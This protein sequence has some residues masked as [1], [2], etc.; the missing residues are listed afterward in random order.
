MAGYKSPG[1]K[2]VEYVGVVAIVAVFLG[3]L[4]KNINSAEEESAGANGSLG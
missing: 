4:W 1:R 3:V 2:I